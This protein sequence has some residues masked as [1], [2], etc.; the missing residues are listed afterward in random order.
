[1]PRSIGHLVMNIGAGRRQRGRATR[2]LAAVAALA[3]LVGSLAPAWAIGAEVESEGEVGGAPPPRLGNPEAEPGGSETVLESLPGPGVGVEVE[4]DE[5]V[6][7]IEAEPPEEVPMPEAAAPAETE[8]EAPPPSAPA[9]PAPA[10]PAAPP[11]PEYT[12]PPVPPT[13]ETSPPPNPQPVQ[14]EPIV[15]PPSGP[16]AR[17]PQQIAVAPE[18]PPPPPAPVEE[19]APIEPGQSEAPPAQAAVLPPDTGR[20]GPGR[21]APGRSSYT[22]HPGDCLWSIAAALLPRGADDARVAAEVARLWRLN[23][24]RIGTGDPDVILVGTTLRIA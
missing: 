16:E 4:G 3:L 9:T 12:P 23:A 6:P 5:E 15:E 8:T 2:V 21:I 13:Y 1:M 19:P 17:K 10:P 11:T 7:P 20:Q 18:A 14:N 24:D 22:V